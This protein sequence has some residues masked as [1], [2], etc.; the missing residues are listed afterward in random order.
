[1][2]IVCTVLLP[3][4]HTMTLLHCYCM[5]RH[6]ISYVHKSLILLRNRMKLSKDP[7]WTTL[8]SL[9]QQHDCVRP[10][11]GST[12]LRLVHAVSRIYHPT[13]PREDQN[14]PLTTLTDQ[15]NVFRYTLC[16]NSLCSSCR[17]T[18][19]EGSYKFCFLSRCHTIWS[20]CSS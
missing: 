9:A 17:Y 13:L 11:A 19:A 10:W 16:W 15:D 7:M 4:I 8:H 1:M 18:E 14:T 3:C 20:S 6:H 5:V 12:I 2:R